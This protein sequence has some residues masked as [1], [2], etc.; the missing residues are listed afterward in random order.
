MIISQTPYRMSFFGGGTDYN[1]Y[2][3]KHGGSVISTTINKYCYVTL[4]HL[5]P[6]FEHKYQIKWSQVEGVSRVED[7]KHPSVR[8]CLQYIGEENIS[9]THDGDLPAR[10]G[11]G[12]SSSFTVG[13]LNALHTL[14]GEYASAEQLAKEAIHV[15]QD[16]LHEHVGVQD[17][18]ASAY[19]GFNRIYF[20]KDGF[21]VR[22]IIISQ[23]RKHELDGNIM[24]FFTGLQRIASEI[25][26]DQISGMD[27]NLMELARIQQLTDEAALVLQGSGS[28][29]EFGLLL[30]EMWELKK[31]LSQ[32][33]SNDHIDDIYAR[34]KEAGAVG[35][36]LMGA[37]GGGFIFFYVEKE[38]QNAVKEALSDLLY[39]P[40]NFES[41]GSRII[42]Y[43]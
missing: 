41:S 22:P 5:P 19:G 3:V 23:E 25:A 34:A 8:A 7:I 20:S 13:M 29:R 14:H 6:F 10:S 21:D 27:R 26:K 43:T 2:Y 15:E 38:A 35:G 9:L 24:L 1:P 39:I 17:Q 33:I 18:I 32:K 42:F 16:I 31:S 11:L 30:D 37:G 12:S 28:L 40:F 36:K 4:R